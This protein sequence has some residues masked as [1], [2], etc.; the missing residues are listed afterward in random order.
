MAHMKAV[1]IYEAGGPEVLKVEDR[2][3]PAPK[4]GENLAT[5]DVPVLTNWGAAPRQ[6]ATRSILVDGS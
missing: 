4:S 1:V 5:M 2:P 3:I 6:E